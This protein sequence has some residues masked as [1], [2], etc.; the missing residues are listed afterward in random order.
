MPDFRMWRIS[1]AFF[2]VIHAGFAAAADVPSP[3]TP[4]PF[5]GAGADVVIDHQ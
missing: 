1:L 5:F 3:E 2:G 4:Y